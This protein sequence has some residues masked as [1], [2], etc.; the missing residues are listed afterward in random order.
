MEANTPGLCQSLAYMK[1]VKKLTHS[2]FRKI[3]KATLTFINKVCHES[4]D[5][6]LQLYPLFRVVDIEVK[7]ISFV[8]KEVAWHSQDW[9]K[10]CVGAHTATRAYTDI[11]TVISF[12]PT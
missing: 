7:M 5:P 8:M 6:W 3:A 9:P 12:T 1:I 10:G 4:S 2:D 11:L